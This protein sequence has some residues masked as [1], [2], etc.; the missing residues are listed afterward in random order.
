M[1]PSIARLVLLAT[2]L[3]SI[4][5]LAVPGLDL[6]ASSLASAVGDG[7]WFMRSQ[8]A[9][10][11]VREI[12]QTLVT[13]VAALVVGAVVLK[14]VWPRRRMLVDGRAALFLAST[15]V[16]GPLLLV[17]LVLKNQWG[18]PRPWMVEEFGGDLTFQPPWLMGGE[19]GHNCS[20]VSGETAGAF[21][22]LALAALAPGPWRPFAYAAVCTFGAIVGVY[23]YLAGGH[24]MSD[25]VLA[26]LLTYLCV[27][28]VHYALYRRDPA[29]ARGAAIE[30]ALERTSACLM[31]LPVALG[32]SL[33]SIAT[34]RPGASRHRARTSRPGAKA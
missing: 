16:L 9:L 3:V 4:V 30:G 12:N 10:E 33:A 20:F 25:V 28:I 6:W 34:R 15:L 2:L 14:L 1:S 7:N 13:G 19:C 21:W 17:N 31:A 29:W 5:Y 26:A 27:W 8:G 18:R 11:H 23:R 22:L 32:R 24:F